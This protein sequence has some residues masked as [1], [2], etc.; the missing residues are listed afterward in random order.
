MPS[1]KKVEWAK[2]DPTAMLVAAGLI[3]LLVI[4]LH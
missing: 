1:D 2:S 4:V 3:V